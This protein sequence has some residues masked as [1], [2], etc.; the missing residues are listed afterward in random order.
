MRSDLPRLLCAE[1]PEESAALDVIDR[2]DE[3][4]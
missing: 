4:L 2:E 3:D 1:S